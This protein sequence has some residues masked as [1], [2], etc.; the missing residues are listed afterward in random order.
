MNEEIMSKI[1]SSTLSLLVMRALW[2]SLNQIVYSFSEETVKCNECMDEFWD[3]L[4]RI[5]NRHL[6]HQTNL[7]TFVLLFTST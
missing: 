4:A 3:R 6:I 7:K 1:T 2:L 5:E